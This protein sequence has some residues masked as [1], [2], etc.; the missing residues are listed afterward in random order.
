MT[1]AT[2]MGRCGAQLLGEDFVTQNVDPLLSESTDLSTQGHFDRR[3]FKES[4]Q[5]PNRHVETYSTSA[6]LGTRKS[7]PQCDNMSHPLR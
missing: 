5:M 7:K 3:F 1:N 6:S 2:K 4:V